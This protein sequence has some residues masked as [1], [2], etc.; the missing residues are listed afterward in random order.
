MMKK[1]NK[2]K[3]GI[4]T[5]IILL[6]VVVVI[7]GAGVAV[8][9]AVSGS[10]SND[11]DDTPTI[12]SPGLGSIFVYKAADGSSLS[13]EFIGNGEDVFLY[14]I[15]SLVS[16]GSNTLISVNKS[17]GYIDNDVEPKS[18]TGSGDDKV[19]TWEV[20][21]GTKNTEIS[22]KKIDGV[23][24]I[25]EIKILGTGSKTYAVSTA[26]S[27]IK[28]PSG[29]GTSAKIGEKFTYSI[30]VATATVP[31]VEGADFTVNGTFTITRLADSTDG[32]YV[33]S[34]VM[35]IDWPKEFPEELKVIKSEYTIAPDIDYRVADSDFADLTGFDRTSVTY[36]GPNGNVS[37]YKY[38]LTETEPALGM[39]VSSSIVIGVTDYLLYES[40]ASVQFDFDA[41]G[42]TYS[43]SSEAE[44][45]YI[46]H[47]S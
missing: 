15:K 5:I 32:N 40:T 37:A 20:A 42:V 14:S 30:K 19:Q 12:S 29:S 25:S 11:S 26:D 4:A 24:N 35:N 36:A 2:D 9:V 47:S 10:D 38:T 27:T 21:I 31:A 28:A 3:A 39:T 45:K 17:N 6:I 46:S 16:S 44:V 1:M 8:Y 34:T 22:I 23:Y 18:T 7:A 33:F 43:T 41:S 13:T